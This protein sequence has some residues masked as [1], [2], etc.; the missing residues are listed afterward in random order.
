MKMNTNGIDHVLKLQQDYETA[1]RETIEALLETIR[2]AQEQLKLLDHEGTSKPARRNAAR[3]PCTRCGGT[4]HDAR[5]HRSEGRST[6]ET[7]TVV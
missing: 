2:N 6:A 3:K 1:R 7:S 5:R 4:D